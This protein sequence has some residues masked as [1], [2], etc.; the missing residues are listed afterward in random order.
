ME[1]IPIERWFKFRGVCKNGHLKNLASQSF[2]G[3]VGNLEIPDFMVS[4]SI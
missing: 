4:D 1:L 2:G 3:T